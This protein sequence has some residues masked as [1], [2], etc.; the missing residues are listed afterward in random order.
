MLGE[1]RPDQVAPGDRLAAGAPRTRRPRVASR[2]W[3]CRPWC[4]GAMR[5][6][7]VVVVTGPPSVSRC[8][9]VEPVEITRNRG[10]AFV[11]VCFTQVSTCAHG[12]TT[13]RAGTSIGSRRRGTDD[14]VPGRRRGGGAP[15]GRHAL[16]VQAR[17]G[18]ASQHVSHRDHDHEHAA[19]AAGGGHVGCWSGRVPA[20]GRACRP[21]RG[22]TFRS[23]YVRDGEGAVRMAPPPGDPQVPRRQPRQQGQ[24]P[25]LHAGGGDDRERHSGRLRAP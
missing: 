24:P 6:C 21:D 25:D 14:L 13:A 12:L 18:A 4:H 15:G 23:C 17:A 9:V 11:R 7:E 1:D 2:R 22:R 3:W 8:D 5:G 20:A 16:P 10:F 19:I